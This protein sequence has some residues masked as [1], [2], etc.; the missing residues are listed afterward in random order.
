MDRKTWS[1][2]LFRPLVI[3]VM[4]GCIAWSLAELAHLL[5]PTWNGTYLVVGCVL[6]ALEANHSYRLIRSRHLESME[7]LRFR[8]IEIAMLF[9]LLRIGSYIGR[10]WTDVLTE[11]QTWPRTPS[12]L[13]TPEI[14]VVF[15]LALIFW[16]A[17]TE[18]IRDLERLKE[19]PRYR[20]ALPPPMKRITRRFFAGGALLLVSA[21]LTR[22]GLTTLLDLNRPSVPGLVVNVLVYF[23]LGLAMVGQAYLVRLYQMWEARKITVQQKL[24]TRWVR[25]SLILFL[26]AACLAFVLPTGYTVGLLDAGLAI[27]RFLGNVIFLVGMGIT[28]TLALVSWFF[29]MLWSLLFGRGRPAPR[30]PQP[31]AR[32]PPVLPGGPRGPLPGWVAILRSVLFWAVLFGVVSYVIYSYL[33]DHPELLAS[34]AN[35]KPLQAAKRL[36]SAL[37]RRIAGVARKGIPPLVRL[38]R[39]RAARRAG[40]GASGVLPRLLRL[41]TLPPRERVRYYYLSILRRAA[42]LGLPRR[43]AQTP[44][45]Y[46][47]TLGAHLPEATEDLSLL[48]QAFVEARYSSHLIGQG[49]ERRA[50]S[51]WQQVKAAL[52]NL[53]RR[54]NA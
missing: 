27:V 15:V 45:E 3:A 29:S 35:L 49:L 4:V 43:P 19:P 47:I 38:R 52:R 54:K 20:R 14:V 8:A 13:L 53:G 26:L 1:E 37:W 50:R 25:Y 5:F 46:G 16:S 34:L 23:L 10:R 17:S 51:G 36:L 2:T 48:T 40:Q 11:I 22:I 7:I 9:V 44:Y 6:A 12:N 41:A 31:P 24:T 39:R 21:G 33:R 18:T 30:P 42:R 28:F 32:V